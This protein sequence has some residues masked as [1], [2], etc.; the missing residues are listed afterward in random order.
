MDEYM[1]DRCNEAIRNWMLNN[2]GLKTFHALLNILH[3]NGSAV[4]KQL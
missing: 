2:A 1:H 3:A 4:N